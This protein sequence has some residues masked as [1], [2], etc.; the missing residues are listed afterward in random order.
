M[1]VANRAGIH[2]RAATMIATVVRRFKR[3]RDAGQGQQQV[4]GTEVLQILSL[5][6]GPGEKLSLEATGERPSGV[7]AW[8]HVL[9]KFGEE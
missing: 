7:G 4:E 9:D 5:G 6:A 2:A 3:P 8:R 1:V